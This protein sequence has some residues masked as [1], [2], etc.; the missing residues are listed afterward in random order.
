MNSRL[1][2][3]LLNPEQLGYNASE[4]VFI[5]DLANYLCKISVEAKYACCVNG[6]TFSNDMSSSN[7]NNVLLYYFDK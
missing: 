6:I 7:I 5:C 4:V 3:V 1:M 2:S